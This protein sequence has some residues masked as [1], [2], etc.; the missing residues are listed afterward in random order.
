[1]IYA[2]P[3]WNANSPPEYNVETKYIVRTRLIVFVKMANISAQEREKLL[4]DLKQKHSLNVAKGYVVKNKELDRTAYVTILIG[5]LTSVNPKKFMDEVV[6]EYVYGR[7]YNEYI[8]A[9]L[10]NPWLR[11]IIED[12]NDLIN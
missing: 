4:G 1:M 9:N 11:I 10:D 3:S 7:M 2:L 6:Y 12:I 8:D 5:G